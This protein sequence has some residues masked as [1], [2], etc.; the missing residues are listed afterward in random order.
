MMFNALSSVYHFYHFAGTIYHDR[1]CSLSKI[2]FFYLQVGYPNTNFGLLTRKRPPLPDVN[3]CILS[4]REAHRKKLIKAMQGAWMEFK[5]KSSN[6]EYD[7]PSHCAF[8]PLSY[9]VMS[10]LQRYF[11]T[12]VGFNF[13]QSC[14]P[15]SYITTFYISDHS[16]F[17]SGI[18][19]K[20]DN[21]NTRWTPVL[22]L[23]L[24]IFP[25]SQTACARLFLV[26]DILLFT[27]ICG[28]EYIIL[29]FKTGRVHWIILFW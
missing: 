6:S 28:V 8:I 7:A 3:C 27:L 21:E 24:K 15:S 18:D 10:K 14:L 22:V 13:K 9:S 1:Q 23:V 2:Y 12:I 29:F 20:W 16:I 17:D 4:R 19:F 25:A 11:G 5:L 26:L